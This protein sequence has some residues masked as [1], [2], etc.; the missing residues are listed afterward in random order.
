M[1]LDRDSFLAAVS[2]WLR[3]RG[4]ALPQSVFFER[5]PLG[6][7]KNSWERMQGASKKLGLS[8]Q[9]EKKRK[10]RLPSS[11]AFPKLA[12]L[13]NGDVEVCYGLSEDG[14]LILNGQSPSKLLDVSEIDGWIGVEID[15]QKMHEEIFGASGLSIGWL[16][17]PFVAN[18]S[19]YLQG[20]IAAL[21]I[22]ALSVMGVLYAMQ[23]Y[24]RVL[25][26][27]SDN[28]LVVLTVGVCLVYVLDFILRM[29]RS[30]VL[31]YAGKQV[32]LDISSSVFSQGVGVRMEAR[33]QQVGTFISQLREHESIAEFLMSSTVFA[34]SDLPFLF[35]YLLVIWVVAGKLVLVPLTV[36]PL[37]I[38]ICGVVQVLLSKHSMN[39]V[40]EASARSG[41][42]IESIEGAETIKAL[43]AEWR[44]KRKWK[45]LT[46]I[47]SDTSLKSN[48]LSSFSTNASYFAQ[49][50]MYVGVIAMGA[51]MVRSGELTAGSLM[52]SAMLASRA[53]A[54]LSAFIS[55]INRINHVRSSS[56]VLNTIMAMPVDR[57]LN[58]NFLTLEHHVGK[59]SFSEVEF[60]Y[61]GSDNPAM[62]VANFQINAG[63]RVAI[64]GR[65]G[66]G[67]TTLLKLLSGLYSATKGSVMLDDVDIHQVDPA[68]YRRAVG[69]MTQDV[70]LF[71][72]T[73][74]E[75]L[76]LG[77][78]DV[79]D[80]VLLEVAG[81]TGVDRLASSHPR[82]F[83]LPI[84]EGGSGL[85]GGQR[86][87]VGL[88]RL[89]LASPLVYLLDEPTASM[90]QDTEKEFIERFSKKLTEK[91]TLVVVTH[92]PSVL[93]LVN[94][95]V[96]V[97]RGCIVMDGARDDILR[98]LSSPGQP[99]MNV[100]SPVYY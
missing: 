62:R 66:S 52:A 89:M 4:H 79:N 93:A 53:M 44:V 58:S 31:D 27:H 25:P 19:G 16:W 7:K 76:M 78:G 11:E 83:E 71:A 22:N 30:Y 69:Y 12:L 32:A 36:I 82:G 90:D 65:T 20:A 56:I 94:R 2:V 73:L 61:S 70:R 21:L 91:N 88:A 40:R 75:N 49:Q 45:E 6:D 51:V 38:V 13:K 96:V 95:I 74:K 81:V 64:L 14:Q 10:G 59:L 17:N 68:R 100:R 60:C 80:D 1:L 98:R 84:Y 47:L 43:N 46:R 87:A 77:V 24:D 37:V 57:P 28:T 15:T 54:P 5:F 85:S 33:P 35:L 50:L 8:L 72:G 42:L 18:W 23:V 26:S 86:Q 97:D 9:F 67:K 41:M 63:E 3:W 39:H 48:L 55:I 99:T 29:L 92:K 34:L